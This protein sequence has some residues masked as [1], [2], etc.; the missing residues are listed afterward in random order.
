MRAEALRSMVMSA[1]MAAFGLVLPIA[2][3]MAGLGSKFLPMLLPILLNGFL[4]SLPWA[5]LTGALVPLASGLLT[6]MP[7]VYPP[8]AGVM[9]IECAL[10]AAAAATVYRLSRP[11][12]WPALIVAMAVDR[13]A[14]AALMWFIAGRFGLPP[15]V[16]SLASLAQGLPGIALQLVVV[17]LAVRGLRARKGILIPDDDKS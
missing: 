17:P 14:S 5:V 12:I 4:S 8:I 13:L 10:M 3:H 9:S 11:R 16:I 15:A 1:V 7:P 2:F 6:G